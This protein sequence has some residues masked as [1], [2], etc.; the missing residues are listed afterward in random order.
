MKMNELDGMKG[1]HNAHTGMASDT[2]VSVHLN[3]HLTKCGDSVPYE[4][5]FIR[6]SNT[7]HP[8]INGTYAPILELMVFFVHS[9][10]R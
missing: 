9:R 6:V 5:R 2:L 4:E 1:L 7:A 8:G 3:P 10:G